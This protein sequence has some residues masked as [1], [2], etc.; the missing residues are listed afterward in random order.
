MRIALLLYIV[1]AAALLIEVPTIRYLWKNEKYA[2]ITISDKWL[3]LN[4]G[5]KN[6]AM[7]VLYMFLVTYVALPRL[8]VLYLPRHYAMLAYCGITHIIGA[9]V[10]FYLD[11]AGWTPLAL[12]GSYPYLL[13]AISFCCLICYIS[14]ESEQSTIEQELKARR[15][16]DLKKIRQMRAAYKN[17]QLSNAE[18]P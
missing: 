7:H 10:H 1:S 14:A 17:A 3:A 16:E 12:S 6:D 8:F 11:S 15:A 4:A 18:K 13:T 2:F 9:I 5:A